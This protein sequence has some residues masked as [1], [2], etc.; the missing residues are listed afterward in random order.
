MKRRHN[1]IMRALESALLAAAGSFAVALPVAAS[2]LPADWQAVPDPELAELRGGFINSDGFQINFSLENVV[3]IDG[4]LQLHTVLQVPFG[5]GKP[6]LETSQVTTTD[7]AASTSVATNGLATLIQNT[8]DNQTIDH[9]RV[10]NV[11]LSNLGGIA[12]IGVINRIQ[13]GLIDSLH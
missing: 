5:S 7:G 6:Q 9:M 10:V 12:G 11:E 8:M 1:C 2:P 4:V 3:S 13:P